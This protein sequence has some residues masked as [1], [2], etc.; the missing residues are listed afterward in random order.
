MD[1]DLS[2]VE[3]RNRIHRTWTKKPRGSDSIT[4]P[5][6]GRGLSMGSFQ[7]D[8]SVASQN[9]MAN[10]QAEELVNSITLPQ[11]RRSRSM[12]GLDEPSSAY[13]RRLDNR[14]WMQ[15]DRARRAAK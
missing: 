8:A 12:W 5:H 14:K 9:T 15:E 1:F 11:H 2:S 13:A 10:Q 3:T 6:H 7:S 4:S